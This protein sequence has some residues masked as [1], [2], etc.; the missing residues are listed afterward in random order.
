MNK[1][2]GMEKGGWLLLRSVK[3]FSGRI[4]AW[5]LLALLHLQLLG[6]PTEAFQRRRLTANPTN[7]TASSAKALNQLRAEVKRLI[8]QPQFAPARWGI[9]VASLSSGR[10]IYE[11][12]ANELFMPASNMKLYTT[13]AALVRLGPNYRFITSLYSTAPPDASGAIKGDLILYG[14]GDPNI[15]A[16]FNAGNYTKPLEDLADRLIAAG[17]KRIEGDIIG[18]ESYFKAERLGP[19][20]EWD[21][22]QWYYGAEVSALSIDD[23]SVDLTV[24]PAGEPGQPAVVTLGPENSYVTVINEVVT[25]KSGERRQIGIRRGL[26]DNRLEI[27]GTIPVNDPPFYRIIAV[28]DP[29][30]FAASLLKSV[31]IRRGIAVSGSARSVGARQREKHPLDFSK[32]TELASLQSLPLSEII[33][34]I[35][36]VSQNLHAELLLRA[37]GVLKGPGDKDCAEAGVQVVKQFLAEAGIDAKL[38]SIRDGSGLARQNL[39]TPAATLQLL[40]FMSHHPYGDVFAASLPVAGVDGT[41][42]RR[43]KETPAANNLHAKTGTLAYVSSLSGYLTTARGDKIAFSFMINNYTSSLKEATDVIDQVCA[44]LAGYKEKL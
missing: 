5:F 37:L 35:N 13:A 4:I 6:A 19:G 23:N 32:L 34:V 40:T 17:I 25:V 21:D 38:L 36:K 26:Q 9:K 10:V 18:D 31:L 33:K 41:L 20:W 7:S 43:M 1:A 28:H 3:V 2:G 24:E 14:R 27:W 29:A 12:S 44:L 42:E 8:D 22:L 16:R 30:G 11:K 39:I 15:S